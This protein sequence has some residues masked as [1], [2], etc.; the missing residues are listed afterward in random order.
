[1]RNGEGIVHVDVSELGKRHRKA[2]V[3]FFFLRMEAQ[4]FQHG[5][6]TGRKLI[7]HGLGGV[8]NA[9]LGKKD[10]NAEQQRQ[11]VCHRF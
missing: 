8:A 6:L 4:V 9:V 1:V 2:C 5:D 7:N 3:V 10:W 11:L